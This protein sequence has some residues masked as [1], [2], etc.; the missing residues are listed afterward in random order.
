MPLRRIDTRY[1]RRDVARLH[2][3]DILR[4]ITFV[5]GVAAA[6]DA[7]GEPH[8]D[9][10]NRAF[11]YVVVL[12]QDCD[13]EQDY[14]NRADNSRQNQDKYLFTVLVCPAYLAAQLKEGT[15]L[16][17]GQKM[18]RL[19]SDLWRPVKN[20]L[21]DRYHYLNEDQ[22]LQVPDLVLDFKQYFTIPRDQICAP[23]L[24]GNYLATL[25]ALFREDLCRRFADYLTRIALPNIGLPT[26]AQAAAPAQ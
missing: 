21:N 4:D 19:S 12:T 24:A 20:N 7:D 23:D 15:H 9:V 8:L 17:E 6:T 3:G 16:G 2:Q 18:Q 13:L 5:E 1:V 11:P 26:P 22:N 10:I 14:D 25:N